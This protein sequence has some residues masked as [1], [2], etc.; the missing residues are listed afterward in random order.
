MSSTKAG[1]ADDA[2]HDRPD[3]AHALTQAALEINASRDSAAALDAIVRSVQHCLAG[4]DHAGVA[5]TH[6]D[7]RVE[8]L[9]ATDDIVWDLDGL[10][11]ELGEG[12]CLDALF[13]EPVVTV[14]DAR[15][16]QR[17]PRFIPRAVERG[18]RGQ[19]GLRLY[20]N[21]RTLAGLNLYST[22]EG[23]IDPAVE[24]TA[25][26]F[27]THAALALGH[28]RQEEH[29]NTALYT[30]KVIGQAIGILMERY[31]LDEDRAFQ[32]LTRAS[33]HGN[34]KLRDLALELVSQVNDR[35]AV[36]SVR[37]RESR[38]R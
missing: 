32:Y 9:A 18:L 1:R 2:V 7:G 12:P 15:H 4:I 34:T 20:L 11:Y 6:P 37:P 25:Q 33:Q 38:G 13:E 23:G 21:G 8:T 30:R 27:A 29:L 22:S 5:I 10:Q 19:M 36:P 28:V 14:R 31:E 26:L 24:D 3:P 17:W 16:E 35:N